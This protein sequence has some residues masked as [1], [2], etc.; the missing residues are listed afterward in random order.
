MR[1]VLGRLVVARAL[2]STCVSRSAFSYGVAA[3]AAQCAALHP[4]LYCADAKPLANNA[5]ILATAPVGTERTM[6]PLALCSCT[7]D[8]H[9]D[10]VRHHC[11]TSLDCAPEN[12]YLSQLR[13]CAASTHLLH[14][15]TL[16]SSPAHSPHTHH[17]PLA[18]DGEAPAPLPTLGNLL[19]AVLQRPLAATLRLTVQQRW[20]RAL[21]VA[22]FD[23]NAKY[24]PRGWQGMRRYWWC[25]SAYTSSNATDARPLCVPLCLR[26][27]LR[28]PYVPLLAVDDESH[29]KCCPSPDIAADTAPHPFLPVLHL[30]SSIATLSAPADV[31]AALV[32]AAKTLQ[33]CMRAYASLR[34][35]QQDEWL[36]LGAWAEA[37][38]QRCPVHSEAVDSAESPQGGQCTCIV[39]VAA[40]PQVPHRNP[41][42]QA[43]SPVVQRDVYSLVKQCISTAQSEGYQPPFD[44]VAMR[45]GH[46]VANLTPTTVSKSV[47]SATTQMDVIRHMTRDVEGISYRV[48]W[49]ED[50]DEIF[51]KAGL[52]NLSYNS[53]KMWSFNQS[54]DPLRDH[55]RKEKRASLINQYPTRGCPLR[56]NHSSSNATIGADDFMPLWIYSWCFIDDIGTILPKIELLKSYMAEGSG[57][58]AY[59]LTCT[60]T[61]L[62]FILRESFVAYIDYFN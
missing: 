6:L 33:S 24:L 42:A 53:R 21:P 20:L 26:E 18:R 60:E 31:A 49:L 57:E 43:L 15:A 34:H 32:V 1:T 16:T 41:V 38:L 12:N 59:Y 10:V 37:A 17:A 11:N 35:A 56:A 28:Q 44:V 14:S 55:L 23:V 30:L 51:L 19:Y 40:M 8:A 5:R 36:A 45:D 52:A 54:F 27:C 7:L 61:A 13:G 39:D 3:L 9:M 58:D 46:I 50:E 4:R 47:E 48:I 2:R 62:S 25:P 22:C 29:D